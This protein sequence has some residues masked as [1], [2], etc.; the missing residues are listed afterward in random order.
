MEAA[1]FHVESDAGKLLKIFARSITEWAKEGETA[2]EENDNNDKDS[3]SS[4]EAEDEKT[5]K[6]GKE[7]LATAE[8]LST[9]ADYCNDVLAFLQAVAVNSPRVIADPLSLRVDK[10]AR[11]VSLLERRQ[12]PHTTKSGSTRPHGS[13]GRLDQRSDQA[14]HHKSTPPR[15][16]CPT[17]GG[18]GDQGVGSSPTNGQARHPGGEFY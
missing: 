3:K 7:K 14:A 10:R 15:R 9:I 5:M 13:H 17:R 16:R 4:V 11:L 2:S 1:I 18:N 6:T 12:P 8:T